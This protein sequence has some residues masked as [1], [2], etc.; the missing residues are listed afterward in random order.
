MIV[1]GFLGCSGELKVLN[2]NREVG[3]ITAGGSSVW[4]LQ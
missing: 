1:S 2:I 4:E 3:L